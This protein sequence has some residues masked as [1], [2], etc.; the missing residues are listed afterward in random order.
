[1]CSDVWWNYSIAILDGLYEGLW[2]RDWQAG[3]ARWVHCVKNSL[4]E[5]AF[6]PGSS[7]EK[8]WWSRLDEPKLPAVSS[9]SF[10]FGLGHCPHCLM[11]AQGNGRA[12][13]KEEG[14]NGRKKKRNL[15]MNKQAVFINNAN[16]V[17]RLRGGQRQSA[18]VQTEMFQHLLDGLSWH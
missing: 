18:S 3:P 7:S 10:A 6:W 17:V 15:W 14:G 9:N 8:P 1:M 11:R 13:G 16:F 2:V 4:N 5:W 12:S